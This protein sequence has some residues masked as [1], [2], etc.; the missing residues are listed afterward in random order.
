MAMPLE[1]IR[2]IDWTIWQQGPVCSA[3][4]GDF[5]N[6]VEHE[7]GRKRQLRPLGE[8]LAAAARQKVFEFKARTLVLHP[9]HA[10]KT[11]CVA[12]ATWVDSL[13]YPASRSN[14]T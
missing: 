6:A 12:V 2:V 11:P 14:P 5:G 7:H 10:F 8:H 4:L 3:L 1:G 13:T 9:S